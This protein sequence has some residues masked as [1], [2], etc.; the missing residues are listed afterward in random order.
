MRDGQT[1]VQSRMNQETGATSSMY[2]QMPALVTVSP[3]KA[4]DKPKPRKTNSPTFPSGPALTVKDAER[5]SS[6]TKR[7][8][9]CNHE[10]ALTLSELV[11]CFREAQDP[12][13]PTVDQLYNSLTTFNVKGGAQ[14]F[15]VC[16]LLFGLMIFTLESILSRVLCYWYKLAV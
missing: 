8:L 11:D 9:L 4:K 6:E 2:E 7:I 13:T 3:S 1:S 16:L 5:L 10:H 15:Q 12:A 14:K